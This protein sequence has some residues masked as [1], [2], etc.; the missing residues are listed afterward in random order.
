MIGME[1]TVAVALSGGLD[2]AVTAALLKKENYRVIGF[3]F[4]TGYEYSPG[5]STP[6]D[7]TSERGMNI[8][9]VTQPRPGRSPLSLPGFTGFQRRSGSPLKL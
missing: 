9:P 8:A 1:K 3:H 2:S 6:P 7:F 5:D 4:R